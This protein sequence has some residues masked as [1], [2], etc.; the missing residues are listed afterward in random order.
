MSTNPLEKTNLFAEFF[1]SVFTAPSLQ[2]FHD[3]SQATADELDY[4]QFSR[5]QVEEVLAK[6]DAG[7]GPGPDGIPNSF[8]KSLAHEFS[9]PLHFLFNDSLRTRRFPSV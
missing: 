8:I 6:L 2:L 5:D 3:N 7:K 9:Q 4:P 1:E